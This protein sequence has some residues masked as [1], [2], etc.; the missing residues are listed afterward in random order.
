MTNT[1]TT[2]ALAM[3]G[4]LLLCACEPAR[5]AECASLKLVPTEDAEFAAFLGKHYEVIAPCYGKE[6]VQLEA[7]NHDLKDIGRDGALNQ[8]ESASIIFL[9]SYRSP[10]KKRYYVSV[11]VKTK[12][13]FLIKYLELMDPEEYKFFCASRKFVISNRRVGKT[14]SVETLP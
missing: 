13:K 6:G 2:I 11:S 10:F 12:D 9:R 4:L 8:A 14:M 5:N 7:K 1:W 3:S